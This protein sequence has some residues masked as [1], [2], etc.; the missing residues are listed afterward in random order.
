[1]NPEAID[2]ILQL[3]GVALSGLKNKTPFEVEQAVQAA[4]DAVEQHKND[5]IT[6]ANLEAQRG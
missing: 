2:I 5:V 1:V 4:Y 6:K 3:L